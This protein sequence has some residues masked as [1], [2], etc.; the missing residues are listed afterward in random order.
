MI[1]S[2]WPVFIMSSFIFINV[3]IETNH[4]SVATS[5]LLS[6]SLSHTLK[7]FI[8]YGYV[9]TLSNVCNLLSSLLLGAILLTSS[10]YTSWRS[11][12]NLNCGFNMVL[13]LT[14][15]RMSGAKKAPPTSFSPVTPTNVGFGPQDFMTFSFNP[16]A[17]LVQNFKFVPSASPKLLNLNQD[18]PSKKA[19]F[20]VKPL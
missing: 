13:L 7:A 14:L 15:F 4:L 2:I 19:I 3:V 6:I 12:L 5:V 10:V 11:L 1:R 9:V 20:L 8:P 18:H 16:F 17:I